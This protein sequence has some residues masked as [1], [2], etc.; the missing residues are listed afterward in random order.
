MIEKCKAL[1]A[2][3]NLVMQVDTKTASLVCGAGWKIASEV[4]KVEISDVRASASN[5]QPLLFNVAKRFC[6]FT[7]KEF[8]NK[9]IATLEDEELHEK[10]RFGVAKTAPNHCCKAHTGKGCADKSIAA[11]VCKVSEMLDWPTINFTPRLT[12]WAP[13]NCS[14]TRI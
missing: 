6:S 8:E 10:R 1:L 12:D 7:R 3:K 11:A 14:C 2:S 9:V 4:M 5:E 13:F